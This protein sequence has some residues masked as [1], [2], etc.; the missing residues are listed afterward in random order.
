M[1]LAV[2]TAVAGVLRAVRLPLGV[3]SDEVG[4]V[5]PDPSLWGVLSDP[6]GGVNPPLLRVWMNVLFE[7]A[8]AVD[9]GRG[10]ALVGSTL[11]VPWVAAVVARTTRSWGLGLAAGLVVAVHPW[12][13]A[14][15]ALARA[16]GPLSAAIGLHLW[17]LVRWSDG[18]KRSDAILA[19][20]G[21]VWTVQQHFLG[22]GILLGTASWLVGSPRDRRLLWGHGLAV[23]S[24]AP[25]LWMG[26]T[27]ASERVTPSGGSVLERML[28]VASSGLGAPGSSTSVGAGVLVGCV[29]ALVVG[30]PTRA[31]VLPM[32]AWGGWLLAATVAGGFTAVRPAVFAAGAVLLAM[33]VLAPL[34]ERSGAR[35]GWIVL[36]VALLLGNGL[37]WPQRAAVEA[38]QDGVRTAVA[39]W[40]GVIAT[41]RALV[42]V[43][44]WEVWPLAYERAGS[45]VFDVPPGCD[46]DP[47][48]FVVDGVL[49]RGRMSAEPG[50]VFGADR[51]G[52]GCVEVPEA[53]GA[54]WR[55]GGSDGP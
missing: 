8:W 11:A 15:G 27:D 31:G 53:P 34:A 9:A 2:V 23:L 33:A 17:G 6:E 22:L 37:A 16:Y 44:A 1:G 36:P 24:V 5:L 30:R 3:T 55:C 25:W 52:P 46:G 7:P 10:L 42:A 40:D 12:A 50:L 28:W 48:C 51:P 14:Y 29:L 21:A 20:A 32:L 49:L 4:N 19:A 47:Y 41:E 54:L 26:L 18:E 45:V 39:A 35:L 43:P 13:V 38:R